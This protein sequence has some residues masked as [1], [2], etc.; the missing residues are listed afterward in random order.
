M[1]TETKIERVMEKEGRE[2]DRDREKE[3]KNAL[4]MFIKLQIHQETDRVTT[5]LHKHL[6]TS[7]SA[8]QSIVYTYS[9]T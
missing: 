8:K 1:E 6:Q 7:P 3:K 5:T 4:L 2:R 9:R